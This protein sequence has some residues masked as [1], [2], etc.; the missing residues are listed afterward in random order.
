MKGAIRLLLCGLI[1]CQAPPNNPIRSQSGKRTVRVDPTA[2]PE[3]GGGIGLESQD[4][5]EIADKMS[6]S[7]LASANFSTEERPLI[8]VSPSRVDNLTSLHA[9]DEGLFVDLLLVSLAQNGMDRLRFVATDATAKVQELRDAHDA[10]LT[11][12]S[13]PLSTVKEADYFLHGILREQF[14]TDMINGSKTRLIVINFTM[15]DL[16]RELVWADNFIVKKS[17]RDDVIYQ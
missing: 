11:Q 12:S 8:S 5:A 3:D 1:A 15:V 9:L 7:I 4:F 13:R 10:G 17:G 2:T 16:N 6:R 14:T